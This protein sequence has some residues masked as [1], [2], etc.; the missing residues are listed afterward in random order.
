MKPVKHFKAF[1]KG[2]QYAR[3][4]ED[5]LTA[6]QKSAANVEQCVQDIC[7]AKV[8]DISQTLDQTA[9][10]LA[11]IELKFDLAVREQ[12]LAHC[13]TSEATKEQRMLLQEF[14]DAIHEFLQEQAKNAS[15]KRR[16]VLLDLRKSLIL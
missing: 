4:I 13:K 3:S 2:A 6:V 7:N 12:N 10:Q 16:T 9:A 8:L 11:T 1:L 15:C 5:N 14:R